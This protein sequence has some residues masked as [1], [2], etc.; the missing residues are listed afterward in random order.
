MTA[1]LG[2]FQQYVAEPV[3]VDCED[4]QQL[5]VN[6]E[7]LINTAVIPTNSLKDIW[8]KAKKL[9]FT[10]GLVVP[11]PGQ[12]CSQ[13]RMVAS[14]H[15]EPHHIVC[16]S[17][18]QFVCSGIC[19][20][21]STY[22]ICQHTVAAAEATN[23]LQKFCQ[24]WKRQSP[25]PD[26]DSLAMSGL[27]KGV[28]GQK[29]GIAKHSR[30]GRS[31]HNTASAPTRTHDRT[32]CVTGLPANATFNMNFG[33][34]PQSSVGDMP[35]SSVVSQSSVG[36]MPQSSV[37]SQSSVG[38][39]P[40]LSVGDMPQSSVVSQSSVGGM[41]QSSV[42]SQSSVGG[43][44]QSS[45][46]SQSSVGFMP[47]LS[48][49]DMPQSSVV[50]QSSVGG[51]PQSSVVSQSSVG[52]MPQSSV[53]SQSSVGGMPQSSVVSQSSVG[54]IPQFS[55]TSNL[56]SPHGVR[57]YVLKFL[58]KQIRICAGCRFGYYNDV[59]LPDPPYNICVS[60]TNHKSTYW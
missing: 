2:S 29:G 46:V 9:L 39:M 25:S 16:K 57:P 40:Q 44:P 52:G 7:S 14:E 36:G 58:T 56:Y 42:V 12:P 38:F 10:P 27:P 26:L 34:M 28:A 53:V 6:H 32:S 17:S 30:R 45:V 60:Q 5:S 4:G 20:R 47:Q 51:M 24:W 49:G 48:V 54:Y 15:N 1:S 22:R 13:N 50:S 21:F 33:Y 31:R 11:V 41:P 55:I 43:M 3:H 35:Q 18:G 19:P 8:I 23:N 37:V 59:K